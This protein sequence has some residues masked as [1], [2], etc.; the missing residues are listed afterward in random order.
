MEQKK[1]ILMVMASPFRSG[2]APD[3]YIRAK[4]VYDNPEFDVDIMCFPFGEDIQQSN[5]HIIRVP[6]NKPF[7]SYQVGEYE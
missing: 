5:V 1:R 2:V 3:N 7:N 6:K 4:A